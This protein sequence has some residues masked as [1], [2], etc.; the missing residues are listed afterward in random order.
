MTHWA[1]IM[2]V[3]IE[4]LLCC[5]YIIITVLRCVFSSCRQ[6][7]FL[8]ERNHGSLERREFRVWGSRLAMTRVKQKNIQQL[9]RVKMRKRRTVLRRTV[10]RRTLARRILSSWTSG[11][12]CDRLSSSPWHV[13]N[14]VW[15]IVHV[16]AF[17]T[18]LRFLYCMCRW[19][20]FS[21][22]DVH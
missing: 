19:V 7:R 10:S 4:T 9:A 12:I 17:L 14:D 11:M 18:V 16:N 21:V 22:K 5:W 20:W 2:S 8:R 6:P 15:S 13:C 1:H 3:F